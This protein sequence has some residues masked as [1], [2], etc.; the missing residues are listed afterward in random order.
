VCHQSFPTAILG[1]KTAFRADFRLEAGNL[2]LNFRGGR[3]NDGLQ[4]QQ[5]TRAKVKWEMSA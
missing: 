3:Y 1:Q 5:W 4:A 2:A